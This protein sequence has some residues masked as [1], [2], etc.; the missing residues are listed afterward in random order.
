MFIISLKVQSTRDLNTS[1][2]SLLVTAANAMRMTASKID[3]NS[4]DDMQIG[5]KD[6]EVRLLFVR[7]WLFICI[8]YKYETAAT[9]EGCLE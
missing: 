4:H 6:P 5:F 2:S 9:P 7:Q 1:G 8:N 3:L